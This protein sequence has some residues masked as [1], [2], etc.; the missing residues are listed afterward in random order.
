MCYARGRCCWKGFGVWRRQ[1]PLRGLFEPWPSH[2]TSACEIQSAATQ[3][4]VRRGRVGRRRRGGEEGE[5]QE[6]NGRRYQNVI[7][8]CLEDK[9]QFSSLKK[10]AKTLQTSLQKQF[11]TFQ[12]TAVGPV[13]TGGCSAPAA[14]LSPSHPAEC[15]ER[16]RRHLLVS[17]I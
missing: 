6:G 10:K 9:R 11:K 2:G 4:Q 5:G 13:L 15:V 1:F 16:R 12:L 7:I 17:C 8:R 14:V 3:G